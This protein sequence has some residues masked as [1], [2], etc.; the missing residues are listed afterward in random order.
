MSEEQQAIELNIMLALFNA[1]VE[2]QSHLN[3]EYKHKT[4]L[5]FND[6]KNKV[7]FNN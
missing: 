1:T 7:L 3:E 2:Q 5:I 6:W 4:K